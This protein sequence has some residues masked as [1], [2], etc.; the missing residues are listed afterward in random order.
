[1]VVP[2]LAL[3]LLTNLL[4]D[5]AKIS[6]GKL[7]NP[8]MKAYDNAVEKLGKR[9]RLN[10]TLIDNFLHRENVKAAIK[11]YLSRPNDSEFL[12]GLTD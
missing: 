12:N 3:G 7:S 8:S 6:F 5:S 9:Y 2:E 1:M 4:S 11:E 10:G